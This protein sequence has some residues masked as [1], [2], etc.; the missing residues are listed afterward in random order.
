MAEAMAEARA[1]FRGQRSE[2]RGQ[3]ALSSEPPCRRKKATVGLALAKLARSLL[4]GPPAVPSPFPGS[5]GATARP[6]PSKTRGACRLTEVVCA[7]RTQPLGGTG[8]VSRHGRRARSWRGR[9][10]EQESE[11]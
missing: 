5:E 7:Q 2:G 9:G 10:G 6:P 3:L 11:R 1:A 8:D 4:L